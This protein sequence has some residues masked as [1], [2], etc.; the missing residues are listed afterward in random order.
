MKKSVFVGG[1]LCGVLVLMAGC[2]NQIP[3][4]D[5]TT[6]KLVVEY[7]AA[8]VREH[9]AN[10]VSELMEKDALQ[11][12]LEREAMLEAS[13]SSNTAETE[14]TGEGLSQNEK[15][16]EGEADV[17]IID[18]SEKKQETVQAS[19]E[20]AVAVEEIEIT[21]AGYEVTAEY[22]QDTEN[23]YFTMGAT[24]GNNLLVLK[25]DVVNLSQEDK[26]LNMIEKDLRY[27]ISV[28]GVTKNALTTMLLNDLSS[29]C[30]TIATGAHEQVVLVCEIAEEEADAIEEITLSIKNEEQ[31]A[32]I[33]LK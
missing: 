26:A 5:E 16:S 29:Y 4:M 32:T 19:L 25:F 7:A 20:E 31:T 15:A 27:Q 18:I 11:R 28:N 10:R 8:V 9:D 14:K 17:E 21:Y 12:A 23:I 2:S 33:S 6:Q 24:A 1:V 22:P 30:D 13:L 3:E